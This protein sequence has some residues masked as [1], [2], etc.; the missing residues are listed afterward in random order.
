[1]ESQSQNPEFRNNPVNFHICDYELFAWG[2][3]EVP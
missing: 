3:K 1:M 2:N